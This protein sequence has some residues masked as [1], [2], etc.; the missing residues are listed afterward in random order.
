MHINWSINIKSQIGLITSKINLTAKELKI[1]Y[2]AENILK[3]EIKKFIKLE[4]QVSG[5][6]GFFNNPSFSV[7][8]FALW[9]FLEFNKF[10][11]LI[12]LNRLN[13]N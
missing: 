4:N 9:N 5:G 1:K 6:F 3:K 7:T 8:A 10:E 13:C 2:K 11:K 12:N